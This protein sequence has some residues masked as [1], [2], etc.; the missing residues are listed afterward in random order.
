MVE[1]LRSMHLIRSIS[2]QTHDCGKSRS[3]FCSKQNK[4]LHGNN[5]RLTAWSNNYTVCVS[6]RDNECL[7]IWCVWSNTLIIRQARVSLS[8]FQE[9]QKW[10]ISFFFSDSSKN[11]NDLLSSQTQL[12]WVVVSKSIFCMV[13]DWLILMLSVI[14][15][16]GFIITH[17]HA[18]TI[19]LVHW[20]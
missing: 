5:L 7:V 3:Q 15:Q 20:L 9:S 12:G 13:L 16:G 8:N 4:A 18:L 1:N 14:H 10:I 17:M 11:A 19:Q 2:Q 6:V